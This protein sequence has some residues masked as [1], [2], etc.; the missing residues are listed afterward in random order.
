MLV[1]SH[2]HLNFQAFEHDRPEVIGRCRKMAVINVGTQ[3]ETARKAVLLAEENGNFFAA[4]A[5]HPIHIGKSRLD[6]SEAGNQENSSLAEMFGQ[7]RELAE[8]K[9]VVAIGE[10]GL[11]Y[12]RLDKD[13]EKIKQRQREYFLEFIGLA[14]KENLPLIIHARGSGKD[15]ADAYREIL[16]ILKK[17]SLRG[18]I[19]CFGSSL[20]IARKFLDIGFY[21]GFTGIITFEKKAEEIQQV[22]R[23][24]PLEKILIETDSPYLAP[25]PYRGQR[26]EP[27]YVERVARKVAALK[28]L[29]LE[30]VIEKTGKN[31]FEL[32][33]LK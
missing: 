16:E 31:A 22:A 30:E 8:E 7:I 19:H 14:E 18:V 21:L 28:N 27:I 23:Q 13:A 33:H 11:D 12:F 5:I 26:N 4:A 2:A 10:T 9:K 32:F 25:E 24:V 6:Q 15:P 20:E 1:D 3:A 29:S 17:K